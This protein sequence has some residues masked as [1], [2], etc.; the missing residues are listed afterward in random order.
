MTKEIL[1]TIIISAAFTVLSLTLVFTFFLLDKKDKNNLTQTEKYKKIASLTSFV[2]CLITFLCFEVVSL[3]VYARRVKLEET[4]HKDICRIASYLPVE[5]DDLSYTEFYIG[6]HTDAETGARRYEFYE[7]LGY[8][9][10]GEREQRLLSFPEKE[11]IIITTDCHLPSLHINKEIGS[12]TTYY[13]IT[14]PTCTRYYF[15]GGNGKNE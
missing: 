5:T 8:G 13:S 3:F 15:Y 9:E 12:L 6:V 14:V 2:A 10:T 7:I 1:L 4:Y 11:L